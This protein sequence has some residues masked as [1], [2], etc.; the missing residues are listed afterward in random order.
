MTK[1]ADEVLGHIG[2]DP[3]S[4]ESLVVQTG[5]QVP[6]LLPLLTRLELTGE[7]ELRDLGYVRSSTARQ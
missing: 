2:Y 7:L 4:L 6:E 1:Q 3:V 5:K